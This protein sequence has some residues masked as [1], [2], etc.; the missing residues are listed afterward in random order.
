MISFS[1]SAAEILSAPTGF[2]AL[3]SAAPTLMIQNSPPLTL[4]SITAYKV[5]HRFKKWTVE[6]E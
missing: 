6:F 5:F 1:S 3:M 4:C 2:K